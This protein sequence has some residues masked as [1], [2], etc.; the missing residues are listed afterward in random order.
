MQL[1]QIP[2]PFRGIPGP[3]TGPFSGFDINNGN[4]GSLISSLLPYI[5][6]AAGILLLIYL[7]LGGLQMMTSKGDPKAMQSAQ[8]KITNALLGFVIII[9]SYTIVQLVA[10]LLGL[11]YTPFGTTFF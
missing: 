8:G 3:A 9:I 7:V 4:V 6:S 1:A 11:R 10:N 2:N 5:F